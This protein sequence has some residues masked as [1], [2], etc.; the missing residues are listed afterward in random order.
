[1]FG[2]VLNN[3][4]PCSFWPPP[5]EQS[6]TT[7]HNDIPA[8]MV[9]AT[10]DPRVPYSEARQMHARWPASRLVTVTG[11][12]RHAVYGTDYGD[13]C[14]NDTVNAFLATG[15]LPAADLTCAPVR[16]TR[17]AAR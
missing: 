17:T 13:A 14:V 1:M 6:V 10:G 9:N 4:T 12:Y 3:V 11:S 5:K 16:P 7:V 8:L 15:R 2:P